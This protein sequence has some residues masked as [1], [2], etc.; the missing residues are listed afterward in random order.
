MYRTWNI[1]RLFSTLESVKLFMR[2]KMLFVIYICK[3]FV[4]HILKCKLEIY[5][6][7]NMCAPP[8]DWYHPS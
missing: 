3:Y 6:S 1:F 8:P 7:P 2:Q 4:T 5:Y